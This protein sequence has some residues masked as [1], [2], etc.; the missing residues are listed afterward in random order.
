MFVVPGPIDTRTGGSIYDRRIA[1]G[2]RARGWSIEVRELDAS[3]PRPSAEALAHAAA[4]L[5]ALPPRTV[6]VV[7]GLA[8]G[9]M[10]DLIEREASRLA[11]VALVHLPLASDVGL[12]R[13][14]AA[15]FE[16]SERRALAAASLVVVTGTA[17]LPLLASSSL[18]SA[19]VVLVEPG[20]DRA[21]VTRG[22]TA[23]PL[24]LLSVGTLNP[25]KG[26]ED[27]LAAFARV[28]SRDWRLTCAGSL[29]RYPATVER[30]KTLIRELGLDEHVSLVGELDEAALEACYAATDVF[31][32]ATLRETYGMAV[33]EA[34]A[35]GLPVVATTTGAIPDL[36][37]D[38][39]GLLVAPGDRQALASALARVVGDRELRE[40]LAQGARR[41]RESLPSWEQAAAKM[42]AVLDSVMHG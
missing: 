2:L 3:F 20:T 40:R 23:P 32:L 17:T 42:A 31:V 28:A 36:V 18:P 1:E 8:L 10:P 34:L 25:G 33:A 38:E 24:R 30:V 22:S 4:V 21:P 14:T 7:D 15:R 12:D 26:H 9:A 11:V 39:A 27:L 37:G 35:H 5:A 29:T 6:T 13:D 41:V 19:R 16:R